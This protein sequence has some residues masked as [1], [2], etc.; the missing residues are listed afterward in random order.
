MKL[1]LRLQ[2]VKAN[3]GFMKYFKNTSWLFAEKIVRMAVGLFVGIWVARYLG[4]SQYGELSYAMAFVGLFSSIATLGLDGIVIR[5]LVKNEEKSG[6]LICTAFYLKLIGAALVLLVLGVAV[7]FTSSDDNTKLIIFIIA[8]SV[9]FQSFNVVDFY[10]QSKVLS[11]YVVYANMFGLLL[12]TAAKIAF[13]LMHA[14]LVAFAWIVF[15]DSIILALGFVYL[16]LKKTSF[17]YSRLLFRR[18]TAILLLKDS[19]SLILSGIVISVYMKIDQVM[20]KE[21]LGNEAVGQ[22]A[23]AVRLSEIW[24]FMPVVIMSSVF[25]SIVNSLTSNKALFYRR[26]QYLYNIFFIFAFFIAVIGS[27]NSVGIITLLFGQQYLPASGILTVYIWAGIFVWHGC[28]RGQYLIA[29][30]QQTIGLQFRLVGM[31]INVILN[32][33]LIRYYGVIGAAY[34]TVISFS[35]PVYLLAIRHKIL[36]KDLLFTWNSYLCLWLFKRNRGDSLGG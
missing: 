30:N 6:E 23:I 8:S 12:S 32:Y 13:L 18:E 17:E 9:V 19:W 29:L 21:M 7:G 28:I 24:Y 33:F 16:F 1:K 11:K 34:A 5:E 14:P 27:M 2:N 4:P 31:V 22:Y 25:P 36:R 15:F 20:I 3:N 10:F 26:I 35:L